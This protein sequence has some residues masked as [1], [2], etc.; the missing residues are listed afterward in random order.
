MGKSAILK[1][2]HSA[3]KNYQQYLAGKT[4]MYVY[5]GKIDE[6]SLLPFPCHN[7]SDRVYESCQYHD[8]QYYHQKAGVWNITGSG[9]D[10]CPDEPKF[11]ATR[12]P[13]YSRHCI[14][15]T[16]SRTSGWIWVVCICQKSRFFRAEWISCS[17]GGNCDHGG[18]SSSITAGIIIYPQP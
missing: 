4:F 8:H 15:G 13:V 16:G 1:K 9:D 11:A 2:I 10:Q 5:E 14:C 7:W 3:A 12:N 17:S 18:S 6:N